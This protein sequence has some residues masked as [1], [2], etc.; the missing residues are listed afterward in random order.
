MSDCKGVPELNY[1][2]QGPGRYEVKNPCNPPT[3]QSP[4]IPGPTGPTGHPGPTGPG[5]GATGPT[6]STGPAGTSV[7]IIGSVASVDDLPSTGVS[8]DA[9]L[10][11][12]H[13]YVWT[14]NGVWEN[15]GQ[16]QGPTGPTGPDGTIGPTGE[17]GATGLTGELGPTGERGE[18][19]PTGSIGPTG[20]IG[21]TGDSGDP[22]QI[23]PTGPTGDI[24]PTG[25]R[26]EVGPTG[27]KGEVGSTGS[28]GPTG[29]QG[30]IG[31]TG[32]Q[33]WVGATGGDG[34]TGPTGAQGIVG[35]TG[36]QGLTG[37][38]G[39]I[40]PTGERGESG[41]DGGVGPTGEPGLIGPT[42]P[43]GPTGLSDTRFDRSV[44][45]LVTVGGLVAGS[46]PNGTIQDL[47][48]R[49]LYPFLAPSFSAFS[50]NIPTQEVGSEVSGNKNFTWSVSN[51]GNVQA[52][53]YSIT[54]LT[55]STTIGSSLTSSPQSIVVDLIKYNTQATHTWQIKAIDAMGSTFTRN[56]SI[57]WR[58]SV[59]AGQLS[60]DTIT[61]AQI[62]NLP[63]VGLLTSAAR[64][65][66]LPAGGYK[67]IC[68]PSTF[69]TLTTFKD[70]DT[71]FDVA[72]NPPVLVSFENVNG[73]VTGYRCHRT[74]NQLSGALTINAS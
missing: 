25:E 64:S 9:Y 51:S 52:G 44:G 72:M 35:P 1:A 36:P 59:R 38:Q 70:A 23:G 28:I 45:T 24:G 7:N 47:I 5:N 8:G 73:V 71:G 32:A 15:I 41:L 17:R 19:G 65:Y 16:I 2:Y 20:Q 53:T 49:I 43:I 48:D 74:F 60:S 26:G 40:G 27:E 56:V 4:G 3:P 57:E 63:S 34:P 68:Y 55:R 33:G 58:Y 46:V 10:I 67:W 66:T 61:S 50:V 69:G 12:G 39:I 21:P 54:D 29:V 37:P 11:G 18:V 13:L 31:P 14:A 62:L 22:G 30:E 42:G 6:G